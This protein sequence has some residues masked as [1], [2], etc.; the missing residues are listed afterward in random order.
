[1]LA[2]D[3]TPLIGCHVCYRKTTPHL[4]ITRL[5][6]GFLQF[7]PEIN[8]DEVKL[9]EQEGFLSTFSIFT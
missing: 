1:M 8:A 4:T 6:K 7:A 5:S 3:L 9:A 2:F